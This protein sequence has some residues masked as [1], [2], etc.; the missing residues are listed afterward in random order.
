MSLITKREVRSQYKKVRENL[1]PNE[2]SESDI[3]IAETLFGLNEYKSRNL[4]LAFVSKDFEVDTERIISRAFKDGKT[5]AVPRCDAEKGV[6]KF[7]EIRSYD[8]LEQG[9][10]DI[11][12]PKISC[13]EIKDFGGSLCVVPGIAYDRECFRVGFGGGYYDRFLNEYSGVSVGVCYSFCVEEKLPTDEYDR[14][15]DILITD[16]KIFRKDNG[17]GL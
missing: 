2:K 9:Y 4:I 6:M 3:K 16:T 15:V 5:V 11:F 17:Y 7:Y 14:P 1:S 10:R 8:D 12:E 13:R